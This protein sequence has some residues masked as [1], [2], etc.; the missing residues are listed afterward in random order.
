MGGGTASEGRVRARLAQRALGHVENHRFA[1]A[2]E[3]GYDRL[4]VTDGGSVLLT[5][6]RTVARQPRAPKR[7]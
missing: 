7:A 1:P 5:F 2:K 6:R 3:H 4:P